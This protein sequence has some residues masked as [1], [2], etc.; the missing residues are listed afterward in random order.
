MSAR[1]ASRYDHKKQATPV[2]E[3]APLF[4]H[5]AEDAL[6]GCILIDPDCLEN[7]SANLSPLSFHWHG[8]RAILEAVQAMLGAGQAVDFVTLVAELNR[9]G[10]LETAGGA[11]GLTRL[12]TSVPNSMHA[13][14]YAATVIDKADRRRLADLAHTINNAAYNP[15]SNLDTLRADAMAELA[16]A[17]RLDGGAEPISQ[18]LSVLFDEIKAAAANPQSVFGI[19][20]GFAD[21]DKTTAGLQ[22]TEMLLLAGEPGTGKS[23]LA[24]QMAANMARAGRPGVIYELEM[25]HKQLSRRIISAMSGV[26]TKAMRSGLVADHEWPMIVNAM[27][28]ASAWPLYVSDFT[29]WTTTSL[30]ADLARLKKQAGIE[31]FVVDYF[32]LLQDAGGDDE[33]EREKRMSGGLKRAC[34]DLDL[35][36]VVVH[37]MNKVGM[38]APV[39]RLQHLSGSNRLSFDAD[40][41][42]FLTNHIPTDGTPENKNLRTLTFAKYR[43][44]DSNRLLHLVKRPGLPAFAD[45]A[46]EPN[47]NIKAAMASKNGSAHERPVR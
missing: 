5:E 27:G 31:W 10:T 47:E 23:L 7:L 22:A 43:E 13:S 41:V 35:A 26:T 16:A 14:S 28:E 1:T 2:N 19:P 29:G 4:D 46:P 3:P 38:A 21:F 36:A 18:S 6:M 12:I 11:A 42:C 20:T 34:K 44:D 32:G 9:R 45:Y 33:N 15:G 40:V 39:K 17:Q 8:H 30:R 24:A 25:G 37:S